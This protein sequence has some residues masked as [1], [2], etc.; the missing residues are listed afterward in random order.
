MKS[1]TFSQIS[2]S[3]RGRSVPSGEY[4]QMRSQMRSASGRR[5]SR[6]CMGLLV[7]RVESLA[8]TGDSFGD[9]RE[10]GPAGN[11]VNRENVVEGHEI[12]EI[13]SKIRVE[14]LQVCELQVLQFAC[15]VERQAHRLA[16]NFMRD[17]ERNAFADKVRCGGKRVQ[18]ARLSGLL[19]ARK[20]GFDG[21]HRARNH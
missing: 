12:V 4:E 13:F 18:A 6:V 10:G 7:D 17:A 11:I 20:I 5:A 1:R 3:E 16:D 15:F 9:A 8:E 19:H 2:A 21:L 14:R